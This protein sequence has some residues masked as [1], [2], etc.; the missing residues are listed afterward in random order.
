MFYGWVVVGCVFVMS[1][2][3]LGARYS[4]GVFLKT[5]EAEFVMT[6]V[7]TS[8]IFSFS[9]LLCCLISI[10]GGWS[11]DRY[12]PKKVGLAM[13]TFTALSF[14]L[15]SQASAT[16]QL[17]ITY[18]L[19]FSLGTGAFYV[20]TNATASRWFVK[21]RGTAL[22]IISA[23]GSIGG[24]VMA[25]FLSFLILDFS[26]RIAVIVAG[27]MILI[28]AIP[29]ASLIQRS[30]ETR[31][32]YPDGEPFDEKAKQDRKPAKSFVTRD[33]LTL[34]QA[35]KMPTYWLVVSGITLRILVTI[36]LSVHLV[37]ILVW[38]GIDEATAAYLVS[39]YAFSTIILVLLMSWIGDRWNRALLCSIGALVGVAALI[40][41]MISKNELVIYLF[42]IMLAIPQSS[43][44]NGWALIGDYFGRNSYAKLRGIAGISVGTGTFLSPIF[45]GWIIDT[46]G[47][48][49]IVL[50]TFAVIFLLTAFIFFVIRLP[51][52]N[53][54]TEKS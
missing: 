14:L 52:I 25:P 30:P 22:A 2:I 20:F 4:Y 51:R 36:A 16:W 7:A 12:G 49:D 11:V 28:V 41:M 45:A 5:I 40:L 39:L 8:S 18:S 46:T 23:A 21:K 10:L 48:Y 31:G 35:L 3:G 17:F 44:A 32:L 33:N 13:G 34:R 6:R 15:T 42:P 19:I 29:A 37:P 53:T 47:S 9:M 54:S 27:A 24:M 1:A 43:A 26:W 38:R 50:M